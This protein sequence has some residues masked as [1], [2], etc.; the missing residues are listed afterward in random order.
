MRARL[1]PKIKKI[2]EYD[3]RTFGT[4]SGFVSIENHMLDQ[5]INLNT[6]TDPILNKP[7][8][9][10]VLKSSKFDQKHIQNVHKIILKQQKF[11]K[12]ARK[13]MLYINENLG[14]AK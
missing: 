12:S 7:T 14:A 13:D 2:R 9:Y 10:S 5:N 8:D 1:D 11:K 3:E 6:I 4:N